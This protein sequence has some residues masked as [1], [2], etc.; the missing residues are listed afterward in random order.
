MADGDTPLLWRYCAQ[1]YGTERQVTSGRW[2]EV[3]DSH[4]AALSYSSCRSPVD[5]V[6]GW[7]V[8]QSV[9]LAAVPTWSRPHASGAL[10]MPEW[11]M[12]QSLHGSE[13]TLPF[14]EYRS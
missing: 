8:G 13:G 5:E 1:L 9:H 11:R 7:A 2:S 4:G 10:P 3:T 14:V 12:N 6:S